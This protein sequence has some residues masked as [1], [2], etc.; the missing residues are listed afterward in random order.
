MAPDKIQYCVPRHCIHAWS[1]AC[2]VMLWTKKLLLHQR[3][4]ASRSC[5]TLGP[6][7]P[8]DI[9]MS[10]KGMSVHTSRL[11][12]QTLLR[13]GS[14]CPGSRPEQFLHLLQA[15]P[16]EDTSKNALIII[17]MCLQTGLKALQIKRPYKKIN[18]CNP[19]PA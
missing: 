18:A 7:D 2:H 19:H 13:S 8:I 6:S 4:K 12:L 5:R 3:Q 11:G 15:Q 10:H 1:E 14:S 16:C 9:F 17:L